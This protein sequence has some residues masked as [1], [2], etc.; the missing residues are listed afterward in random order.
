IDLIDIKSKNVRIDMP[1][2]GCYPEADKQNYW[3]DLI[4]IYETDIYG[5]PKY[6][7]IESGA[8][9]AENANLDIKANTRDVIVDASA[10]A[11]TLK[12]HKLAVN[13]NLEMYIYVNDDS[14]GVQLVDSKGIS[15]NANLSKG[16]YKLT[17][18]GK[19]RLKKISS[20]GTL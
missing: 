15:I 1:I 6:T 19:Y 11:V 3:Q 7:Y 14:K 4:R 2:Y 18:D 5:R 8:Q 16:T 10:A 13:M 12:L 20:S 17:Y 9:K